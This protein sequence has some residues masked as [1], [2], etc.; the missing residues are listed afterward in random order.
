MDWLS[1]NRAIIDC[2][3]K[4]VLLRCSDQTE[5]IIQGIGS[6]V[7]SNVV[8]TMQARKGCQVLKSSARQG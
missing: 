2:G 3:Q 5:V 1:K 4:T 8:S 7:M 6:S